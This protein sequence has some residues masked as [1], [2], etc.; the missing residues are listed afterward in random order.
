ML[1]STSNY[2]KYYCYRFNGF[3]AS[4]DIDEIRH[5]LEKFQS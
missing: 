4:I 2:L 5:T 1:N 3:S